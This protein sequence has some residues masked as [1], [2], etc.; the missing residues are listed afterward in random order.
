MNTKALAYEVFMIILAVGLAVCG[1]GCLCEQS[2]VIGLCAIAQ[3][4][5]TGA[6]HIVQLYRMHKTNK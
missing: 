6:E 1:I 5:C 2:Y 4:V 3:A